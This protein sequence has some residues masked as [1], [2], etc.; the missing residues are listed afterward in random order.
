MQHALQYGVCQ[1]E[2][3]GML[4]RAGSYSFKAQKRGMK[5]SV[6]QALSSETAARLEAFEDLFR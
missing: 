3:A 1:S 4:R 5:K 6:V 2:L